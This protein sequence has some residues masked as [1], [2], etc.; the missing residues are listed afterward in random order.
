M[1]RRP[2]IPI[3][4]LLASTVAASGFAQSFRTVTASRIHADEES[5]H[6]E[7]QFG[8]GEL[9]VERGNGR[10]LYRTSLRYLEEKFRPITRYDERGRRL[11]V[12]IEPRK[13]SL[14]IGTL[15]TPQRLELFLSP[16]VPLDLNADV[17][18]AEATL[19]LGGLS[20]AAID[21]K[22]GAA[23][24]TVSFDRPNLI[25]CRTLAIKTGAAEFRALGLG[26]SRCA[27]LTFAGGAGDITL[28]FTGEWNEAATMEADVKLTFGALQL[29]FPR[30]VGVTVTVDRLLASFDG[31]SFTRRGSQYVSEGFESARATM[32]LSLK[33]V[34][35]DID[36]VWVER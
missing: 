14:N 10:A 21:I 12:G 19:E 35:G 18:A 34:V 27:R 17:G 31:S 23:D 13:G 29:R 9:A 8:A 5:L 26:N 36:V 30:H 7:L 6:V 4:V 11:R 25:T 20:I 33:A 16:S 1:I 32:N 15:K 22:A 28:D 24:A 2:V 3:V